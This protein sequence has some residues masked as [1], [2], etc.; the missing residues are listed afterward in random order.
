MYYGRNKESVFVLSLF[1]TC[2]TCFG[3]VLC[4]YLF[5]VWCVHVRESEPCQVNIF[6]KFNSR[7]TRKNDEQHIY[8][9]QAFYGQNIVL[10]RVYTQFSILHSELNT[11]I[12]NISSSGHVH[13]NLDL[14]FQFQAKLV[15]ANAPHLDI[16]IICREKSYVVSHFRLNS[17][18]SLYFTF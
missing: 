5:I 16:Y 12:R 1:S 8:P 15:V 10:Q 3:P 14:C 9:F 13:L 6:R 4:V 7:K 11:R 17:I 2:L 18:E